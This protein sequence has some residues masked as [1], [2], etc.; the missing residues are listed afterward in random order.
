M[1]NR[2][3]E[4]LITCCFLPITRAI[5][6]ACLELSAPKVGRPVELGWIFP[7]LEGKILFLVVCQWG[8]YCWK[9]IGAGTPPTFPLPP[10]EIHI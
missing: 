1:F 4:E 2:N 10:I 7:K 8:L 9:R 3:R 5:L 6:S